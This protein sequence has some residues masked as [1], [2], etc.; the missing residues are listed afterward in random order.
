[1]DNFH[2]HAVFFPLDL[3]S[4]PPLRTLT[5]P[6]TATLEQTRIVGPSFFEGKIFGKIEPGQDTCSIIGFTPKYEAIVAQMIQ[7]LCTRTTIGAIQSSPPPLQILQMCIRI[8]LQEFD[9]VPEDFEFRLDNFGKLPRSLKKV[10]SNVDMMRRGSAM[11]LRNSASP[12]QIQ[13][14]I[15][16]SFQDISLLLVSSKPESVQKNICH[17]HGPI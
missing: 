15:S 11:P 8:R 17:M 3:S 10:M 16:R 5:Y 9:D 14:A 7:C 12:S 4:L 2:K 1:M 13:H 6:Y